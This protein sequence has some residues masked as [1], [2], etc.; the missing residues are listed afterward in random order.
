LTVVVAGVVA[1]GGWWWWLVWLVL[2]IC[3]KG[4]WL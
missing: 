3:Q 2:N 1:G 4:K